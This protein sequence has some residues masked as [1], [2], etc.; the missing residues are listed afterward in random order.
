MVS[1]NA[2]VAEPQHADIEQ[3]LQELPVEIVKNFRT[4]ADVEAYF[5]SLG[6]EMSTGDEISDG[7]EVLDNKDRLLD[8]PLI[9]IDWREVWSNENASYFHT[10][11]VLT[12]S[13]ERYRISDGSTGIS[14]QLREITKVRL[15]EGNKVP[16][17]GLIVRAGL[18]KSEYW[19]HK[20]EGRALSNQE[21]EALPADKKRKAATYYL[22]L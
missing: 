16:N 8:T 20:D 19:V 7:Y 5:A 9:V 2:Q 3:R 12:L 6:T 10:I 11:R 14:D 22:N 17:A 1:K 21:A 18:T 4:V 13:G 15:N